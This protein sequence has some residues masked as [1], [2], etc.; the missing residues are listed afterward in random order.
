MFNIPKGPFC[1]SCGIPMEQAVYGTLGDGTLS[2][3]YCSYCFIDGNF[4]NEDIT[5]DEMIEKV[6]SIMQDK[7]KMSSFQAKFI[8]K[9]FIPQLERWSK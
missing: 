8:A 4:V 7:M 1:Q 6:C 5:L 2:D 3:K 9:T